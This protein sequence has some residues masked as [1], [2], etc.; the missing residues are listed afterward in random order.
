MAEYD[1]SNVGGGAADC[2]SVQ[3]LLD[4]VTL[5]LNQYEAKKLTQL[6]A[7]LEAFVKKKAALVEE[8]EKK[9]PLL[10]ER[11]CKQHQDVEAL[12]DSLRC[13]F[14]NQDWKQ[15]ISDCICVKQRETWCLDQTIKRRNYC[16]QGQRERARD[17][18]QTA[19]DAAQLRMNVLNANTQSIEAGLADG[20]KLI[21]E[22]QGL[23]P[24][25]D[26][27]IALF[28]FWFKLLPP[29]VGL[30]PEDVSPECKKFGE[31]ET[32]WL[33]C[34]S[35]LER[36]CADDNPCDAKGY[37]PPDQGA[38]PSPRP[39]PWLMPSKNYSG[40]LDRAWQDYRKA[41]DA[42]A[43]AQSQ[44]KSD[45]D[46]LVSLRAKLAE[47][48]KTFDQRVKD[49]LKQARPDDKC[50]PPAAVQPTQGANHA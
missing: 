9:F 36:D 34:K 20:D 33:L 1:T 37:V 18:A 8:Y 45:P 35:V 38:V 10:R 50:C 47:L 3:D 5:E 7:D 2:P 19:F 11:W 39:A 42:H 32:P 14:P 13:A 46:D 24:G 44:F 26:K 27:A 25:P 6:K 15:L 29:H 12:S 43:Q 22:I 49:C 4:E 17:A 31:T 30:M 28:L 23:V 21:K 41:K 16:S 40:D 48:N